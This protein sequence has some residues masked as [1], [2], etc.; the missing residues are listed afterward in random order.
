MGDGTEQNLPLVLID[1]ERD[2]ADYD[3]L[4]PALAGTGCPMTV[5]EPEDGSRRSP[6]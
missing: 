6:R 2:R 3:L 4:V 1:R 5:I